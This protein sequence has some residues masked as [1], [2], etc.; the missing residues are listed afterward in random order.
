MLAPLIVLIDKI[1]YKTS[2]AGLLTYPEYVIW[3]GAETFIDIQWIRA[4]IKWNVYATPF[5][6]ARITNPIEKDTNNTKTSQ[7]EIIPSQE[8]VL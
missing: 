2:Q 8:K 5:Y 6:P 3:K 1:G 7:N 4:G